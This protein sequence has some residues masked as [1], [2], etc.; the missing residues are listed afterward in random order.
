M[1]WERFH[2]TCRRHRRAPHVGFAE[3]ARYFR[4]HEDA[5][6]I[7]PPPSARALPSTIMTRLAALSEQDRARAIALYADMDLEGAAPMP[8]K[9]LRSIAYLVAIG[10]V[11]L[12]MNSVFSLFVMPNFEHAFAEAG[13][14]PPGQRIAGIDTATLPLLLMT[15]LTPMIGLALYALHRC[16]KLDLPIGSQLRWVLPRPIRHRYTNIV[17]LATYPLAQDASTAPLTDRLRAL[18]AEGMDLAEELPRMIRH[19]WSELA[20]SAQG[21]VNSLLIVA[22]VIIL[23]TVAFYV[24]SAYAPLFVLESVI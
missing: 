8:R 21:Y 6:L 9:V 24:T 12:V 1:T 18:E 7:G 10:F 20:R 23:L 14:K 11:F 5:D 22:A 16:C 19:Q 13:L 15:L 2:F 3:T 17:S 4:S